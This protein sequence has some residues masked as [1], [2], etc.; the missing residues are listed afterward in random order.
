[1]LSNIIVPPYVYLTKPK[2]IFTFNE[3][4]KMVIILTNL[5]DYAKRLVVPSIF[6]KEFYICV[7][8]AYYFNN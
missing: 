8:H 4:R 1:M 3:L 2:C 7:L 6:L 5:F